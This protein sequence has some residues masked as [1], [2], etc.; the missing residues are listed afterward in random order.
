MALVFRNSL[1]RTKEEF[2]P[3]DDRKVRMYTCGP[4][5]YQ[6]ASIG[7]FRTYMFEDILRRYLKYRAYRV[8]QVMNLTD[9][10]DKTI[11]DSRKQGISLGEHTEK[12]IQAFFEDID[13]LGIERAEYY[14]RATEHVGEMIEIVL[15]LLEK[16]CA[17]KGEDGSVYFRVDAFEDYGKLARITPG[18]YG[19]FRPLESVG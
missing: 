12:Y 16:R 10:D 7:N 17:Y 3:I 2:K 13:A 19:R 6:F 18:V 14:P 1:T 4:T 15:R 11:R 8:I 5:V 9:V